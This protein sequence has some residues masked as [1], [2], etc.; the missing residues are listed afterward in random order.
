MSFGASKRFSWA[1]SYVS[2]FHELLKK[3]NTNHINVPSNCTDKLQTLNLSINKSL[4]DE[5]KQDFQAWY[6]EEVQKQIA[7]GT[8]ISDV[9]IDTRI[10]I[11]TPNRANWLIGAMD[12]LSQ[13]PEIVINGFRKV[14]IVDALKADEQ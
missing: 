13:K 8:D 1:F 10:S 4:K 11:L 6:A 3:N 7:S 5:M 12:F 9:E 2:S 14:G